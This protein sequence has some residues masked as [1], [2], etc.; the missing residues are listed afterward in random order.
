LKQ[1]RSA[2]VCPSFFSQTLTKKKKR[3]KKERNW[4]DVK[5]AVH[6]EKEE[7]FFCFSVFL[8]KIVL[9]PILKHLEKSQN[10]SNICKT[11]QNWILS[12]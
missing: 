2:I 5:I 10:W 12:E 7:G 4:N 6:L 9:Q 11:C 8:N 3:K 1:N